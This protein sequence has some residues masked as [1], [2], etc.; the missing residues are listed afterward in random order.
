MTE[1]MGDKDWR[2]LQTVQCVCEK[3]VEQAK[4]WSCSLFLGKSPTGFSGSVCI[5][6]PE[7]SGRPKP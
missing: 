6:T 7:N 2:I 3:T 1:W 4:I 5:V